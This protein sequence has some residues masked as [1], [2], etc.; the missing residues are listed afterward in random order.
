MNILNLRRRAQK[1]AIMILA[2]GAMVMTVG[3][4]AMAVDIG[5]VMVVRNE[6]QN[7]ADAAALA[8]AAKLSNFVTPAWGA[9]CA[10]AAAA[11]PY[12]KSETQAFTTGVI[13]A[14]V[15]SID[16]GQSSDMTA[17]DCSGSRTVVA[18]FNGLVPAISVTLNRDAGETPGPVVTFFARIFGLD[19]LAMQA[20]SVAGISYPSNIPGISL[21]PFAISDCITDTPG[22]IPEVGYSEVITIYSAQD[23]PDSCFKGQ[24]TTFNFTPSNVATVRDLMQ[25]DLEPGDFSLSDSQTWYPLDMNNGQDAALFGDAV[26]YL[27]GKTVV[28]PI[29]SGDELGRGSTPDQTIEGFVAFEITDAQQTTGGGGAGSY[30]SG[31]FTR[32]IPGSEPTT[33]PSPYLGLVTSP[34]LLGS[35]I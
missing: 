6:L 14:G 31:R 11:I 4:I 16:P 7:A 21:A 15:W 26:D 19:N 18:P 20:T 8:G 22:L 17:A 2:T 24:W 25:N 12:N 28:M 29:V 13:K 3:I 30:I 34:K 5:R 9:A 1:G 35:A 27:V 32:T 23:N 10:A 33:D